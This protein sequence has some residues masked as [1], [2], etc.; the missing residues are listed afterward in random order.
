MHSISSS[1]S[2]NALQIYLALAQYPILSSSIRARMRRELFLRGVISPAIFES[3]V[4]DRA[5]HSQERE[6]L[7]NPYTEEPADVWELRLMRIRDYLTD[8]Y[9]AT[10]LPYE[11]FE[12]LVRFYAHFGLARRDARHQ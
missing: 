2:D 11:L 3:E 6:A 8:F 12:E 7:L 1:S 9:F 5:I 10:N 4:H